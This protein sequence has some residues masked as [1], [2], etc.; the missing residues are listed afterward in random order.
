MSQKTNKQTYRELCKLE[1]RIHIFSQ[2]WWLDAVAGEKNWDV[3]L[4]EENGVIIASFPYY[5]IKKSGFKVVT[6]PQLTPKMGIW[7]RYPNGQDYTSKLSYEKKIIDDLTEL[8]PPYDMFI[9]NFDPS[10]VNWLPFYWQGF[11]QTTKYTYIIDDL[12]DH[13]RIYNNFRSNVKRNIKKAKKIVKISTEYDLP[14]FYEVYKK[15]FDRQ[16]M[17]V[18]HT[19]ELLTK[20]DS[21]CSKRERRKIFFAEDPSG[22]IHAAVYIIWDNESAYYIMGGADPNLRNSGAMSLLFWEAIKFT[23]TFVKRFDFEGSMIE[24]IERFVRTFG[25]IQTPY[26]QIRKTNSMLLAI[27]KA[28]KDTLNN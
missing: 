2:D 13:D 21:A 9:Q 26:F 4:V 5:Y 3:A 10:F 19:L 12:T 18:P 7:I 22:Q 24:P 11:Q 14:T 28:I 15:T 16:N 6:M 1:S 20:I 23:S 25:G 8:L 27:R 17:T